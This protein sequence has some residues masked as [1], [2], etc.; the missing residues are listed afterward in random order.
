MEWPVRARDVKDVTQ[1]VGQPAW[2]RQSHL[3]PEE[4]R[5]KTSSMFLHSMDCSRRNTFPVQGLQTGQV[6]CICAHG[7][8][9]AQTRHLNGIMLLAGLEQMKCIVICL[10]ARSNNNQLWLMVSQTCGVVY[11]PIIA[12]LYQF[13]LWKETS[14]WISSST[15][16]LC[17]N[18]W[19]P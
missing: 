3:T 15:A 9:K 7:D 13:M 19:L 4:G 17:L 5:G 12:T 2:K 8:A 16:A 1:L 10:H 6:A 11:E 18:L 14:R